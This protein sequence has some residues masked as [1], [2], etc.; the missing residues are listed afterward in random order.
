VCSNG[1]WLNRGSHHK[2][3][4][5]RKARGSQHPT[6][7][8]L[9]E[10]PNKCEEKLYSP[11]PEVMKCPVWRMVP[12]ADLKIFN[13]ELLL[14]KGNK[15]IKHRAEIEGKTIQRLPRPEDLSS[16]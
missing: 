4:V 13:P 6:E 8:M 16:I 3:P 10:I 9:A 1:I 14:S 12:P 5:A 7:M 11:Y 15:G 2:V